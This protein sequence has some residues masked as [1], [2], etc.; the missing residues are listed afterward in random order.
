MAEPGRLGFG[1][2]GLVS[3]G[4][5]MALFFQIQPLGAGIFQ[6]SVN[7][8]LGLMGLWKT[9][10]LE[11]FKTRSEN[12]DFRCASFAGAYALENGGASSPARA[13]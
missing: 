9:P 6:H 8:K 11:S 4:C 1:F 7:D 10:C 12:C 13:P 5:T 2:A 3:P